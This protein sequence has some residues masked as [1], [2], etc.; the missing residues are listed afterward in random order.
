V[1]KTTRRSSGTAA[2]EPYIGRDSR[3]HKR[4]FIW[5][6]SMAYE[7]PNVPQA[8][9][10]RELEELERLEAGGAETKRERRRLQNRMAQRAYR[11]RSKRQ[12]NTV[13]PCLGQVCHAGG[14]LKARKPR[15]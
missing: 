11:A 14:R 4:K 6:S 12:K 10:E 1:R 2:S 15:I 8:Q 13:N 7:G 3:D 5:T 9:K